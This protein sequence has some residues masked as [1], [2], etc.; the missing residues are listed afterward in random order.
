MTCKP[1]EA[2]TVSKQAAKA[3]EP[4]DV[5]DLP[6]E[7]EIP[8][9]KEKWTNKKDGD[10]E[11]RESMLNDIIRSRRLKGLIR[12]EVIELLGEPT[13]TDKNYLFY[14]VSEDRLAVILL[15]STKA[16][17]IQLA[18]EGTLGPVMVHG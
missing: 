8:L 1:D 5:D 9:D 4:I 18:D 7:Q 11:Y 13:R 14:R 10:Y 6:E 3:E 16:L 15:L 12:E 17:V 2:Q